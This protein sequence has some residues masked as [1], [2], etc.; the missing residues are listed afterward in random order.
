MTYRI[1]QRVEG[2]GT[3][4]LHSPGMWVSDPQGAAV[5]PSHFEAFK[6]TRGARRPGLTLHIEEVTS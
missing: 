4:Y 3:F 2:L 6:A 5:Y 1:R